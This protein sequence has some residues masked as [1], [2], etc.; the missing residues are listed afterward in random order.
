MCHLLL[1]LPDCGCK[2]ERKRAQMR[3]SVCSLRPS[4]KED[5]ILECRAAL[6]GQV[7]LRISSFESLITAGPNGQHS[8]ALLIDITKLSDVRRN[9]LGQQRKDSGSRQCA[10]DALQDTRPT[11]GAQ[12]GGHQSPPW[13]GDAFWRQSAPSH[14]QPHTVQIVV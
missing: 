10:G 2:K 9:W 11:N 14:Q 4:R 8:H 12:L 5:S 6:A 13:Q 3:G 1:T 7:S